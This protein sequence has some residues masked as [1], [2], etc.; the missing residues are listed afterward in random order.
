MVTALNIFFKWTF[1][2]LAVILI[3]GVIFEQYARWGS[4]ETSKKK[5]P[6]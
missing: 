2:V 5:R 3:A 6:L 4:K 1:I